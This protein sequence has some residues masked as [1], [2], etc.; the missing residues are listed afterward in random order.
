[1][2]EII[3]LYAPDSDNHI[4][5]IE[6]WYDLI[7]EDAEVAAAFNERWH[8]FQ[9]NAEY[10]QYSGLI[11][12]SSTGLADTYYNYAKFKQKMTKEADIGGSVKGRIGPTLRAIANTPIPAV[13]CCHLSREYESGTDIDSVAQYWPRLPGTLRS[14]SKGMFGEVYLTRFRFTKT[15]DQDNNRRTTRDYVIQAN[16][17]DSFV[18][19]S[20]LDPVKEMGEFDATTYPYSAVAKAAREAGNPSPHILLCGEPGTGKSTWAA[21]MIRPKV[22]KPVLVLMFDP[23]DKATPY[24]KRGIIR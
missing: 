15:R 4:A 10:E 22:K 8:N 7:P 2:Q 12:D 9:Y 21:T 16:E 24:M 17:S 19:F 5:Q 18:A 6:L 13:V 1:M 14:D 23:R 11:V 20:Q 3:S